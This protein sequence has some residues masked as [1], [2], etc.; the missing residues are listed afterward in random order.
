MNLQVRIVAALALLCAG[1]APV[2]ETAYAQEIDFGQIDKFESLGTGTLQWV[3]HQKPLS[4]MVS[5]TSLYSRSGTPMPRPKFTGER[6]M[7]MR[8]EQPSCL[9][10]EYR[11]FKPQENF[12]LRPSA[13]QITVSNMDTCCTCCLV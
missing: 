10:R 1:G 6:W 4:M 8:P 11:R 7:E 12:D 2:S 9:E 5:D 13:S 3:R